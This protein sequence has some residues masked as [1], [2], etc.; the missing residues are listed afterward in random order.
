MRLWIIGGLAVLCAGVGV[1]LWV[2]K[3]EPREPA[4]RP[5]NPPVAVTPP[6]AP[7]A[8]VV[9]GDVV[10]V[11]DLDPLLDPPAKNAGGTP[12]DADP[13]ATVPVS[14]PAAPE[15]SPLATDEEAGAEVAPMPRER[16]SARPVVDPSRACWYGEHRLPH[17]IGGG[18]SQDEILRRLNDVQFRNRTRVIPGGVD[19]GVGFYF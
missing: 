6:A 16:T 17:Q 2:A 9:L 19:V 3:T 4:R 18:I 10:E 15:R 5:E 14:A 12:F 1:G 7:A 11:A 8:A 13:P